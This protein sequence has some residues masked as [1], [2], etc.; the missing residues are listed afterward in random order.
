[1]ILENV[2]GETLLR[3]NITLAIAESCTGG[4][5]SHKLTEI[6]GISKCLFE[7]IVA[8]SNKSKT[9]RLGVSNKMIAKYG[10]VSREVAISMAKGVVKT[11]RA[12]IGL[13]TNGIAGPGGGSKE[14]P[15]GLVF[16]GLYDRNSNKC[17]VKRFIFFGNRSKIKELAANTALDILKQHLTNRARIT[18]CC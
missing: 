9:K 15:V 2:V 18:N 11:T 5:L 17:L 7:T 14:K 16:I 10:A 3:N 6:H 1:M 13:S 8:Y 4:L 12:D